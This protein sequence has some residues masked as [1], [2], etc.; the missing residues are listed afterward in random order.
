MR[1]RRRGFTLIELL[2]VIA[3]IAIL[4]GLLLPAVQK[5]REAAARMQCQNNLKQIGLACH[6]YHD[7]NRHFPPGISV[8]LGTCSGCLRSSACSEYGPCPPQA[9]PGRWGSWLTWILPYMERANVFNRMDLSQRDYA[10]CN[11]PDSP[12]ATV[13]RNYM[14]PSDLFDK[15]V[16]IYQG[17]FHFGLNSYYANAG[18][19]SWPTSFA[20]FDGVMYYNSKTRIQGI[21]DGTSNTLLAGERYHGDARFEELTGRP[22]TD[23]NGWAWNNA[24]SGQ[25]HLGDTAWPINTDF[26]TILAAA[27][28]NEAQT[29]RRTV[30]GSGHTGGANFVFC[31]GSVHFLNLT[32]LDQLETLQRLSERSDGQVI[33]GF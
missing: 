22:L 24:N 17:R 6:N 8:P 2:V 21:S 9:I 29:S 5:V 13:I 27:G 10:Y 14:C 11:G 31:D 33:P 32:N 19:R 15:E 25:D 12:G 16:R 28:G 4:I 30:F 1:I 7:V 20:T 3:I 18:T 23:W 26:A